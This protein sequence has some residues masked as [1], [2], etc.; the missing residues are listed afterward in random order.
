MWFLQG[1]H[2]HS[3]SWN[4]L[5]MTFNKMCCLTASRKTSLIVK[6]YAMGVLP[7]RWH[8]FPTVQQKTSIAKVENGI[9]LLESVLEVFVA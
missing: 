9:V 5:G 4:A 7:A 1:H 8:A 2:V 6:T 3:I